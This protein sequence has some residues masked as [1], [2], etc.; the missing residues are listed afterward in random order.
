MT[1]EMN[2]QIKKQHSRKWALVL[3]VMLLVVYFSVRVLYY[4]GVL[5]LG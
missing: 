1:L 3:G 4:F 2:T 5:K